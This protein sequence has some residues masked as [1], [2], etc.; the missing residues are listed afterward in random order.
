[1]DQSEHQQQQQRELIRPV[2]MCVKD[3]NLPP[4]I[5]TNFVTKVYCLL[6]TMLLISFGIAA[7]FTFYPDATTDFMNEHPWIMGV[8]IAMLLVQQVLNM[9]IMFEACCGGS[10]LR[11]CYFRMFTRVPINYIFLLSYAAC[12]GVLIGVICTQYKAES[13]VIVFALTAAIM[14]ALTV[15]AITTKSDFSGCGPFVLVLLVSM[16]LFMIVGIFVHTVFIQKAIAVC[17]ACLMGFIIVFD[18]QMIFGT[19]AFNV[20]GNTSK[21]EFTIDMYAFGAYQLYLDFVNMFLYLL[22]IFGQRR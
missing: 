4:E 9:A 19:A 7:P 21:I 3:A 13:V 10:G 14:F 22:Q 6:L 8:A 20:S 11:Q 18:T 17:G 5:R 2:Q 1:M 16:I 12:F 15:Y